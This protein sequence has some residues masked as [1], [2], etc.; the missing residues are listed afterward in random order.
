MDS[1]NIIEWEDINLKEMLGEM[2]QGEDD[3]FMDGPP[4][5]MADMLLHKYM[6]QDHN[7][8]ILHTNFSLSKR[9]LMTLSLVDGVERLTPLSRYRAMFYIGRLFEVD[10]VK[11]LIRGRINKW[12]RDKELRRNQEE[13][14]TDG[15]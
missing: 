14:K 4:V 15:V 2:H 1:K 13:E 9:L 12:F 8:H 6:E 3:D 10:R 5:S 11:G 7:F